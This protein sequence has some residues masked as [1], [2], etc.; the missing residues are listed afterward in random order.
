M[1]KLVLV[2][3]VLMLACRSRD[4]LQHVDRSIGI[5]E[6]RASPNKR[7]KRANDFDDVKIKIREAPEPLLPNWGAANSLAYKL[8]LIVR[9]PF[10]SLRTYSL[11]SA[12]RPF[13]MVAIR[14]CS[15]TTTR[16]NARSRT[17]SLSSPL[18]G[19]RS[20]TCTC[21]DRVGL[22][23]VKRVVVVVVQVKVGCRRLWL[24]PSEGKGH[25]Q[26]VL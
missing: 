7:M 24:F 11:N 14:R 6:D 2:D 17:S 3:S 20:S 25:V 19:G 22:R 4:H 1:T 8:D 9:L 18:R 15:Q 23:E 13:L 10:P 26:I 16:S 5:G 21:R 12:R